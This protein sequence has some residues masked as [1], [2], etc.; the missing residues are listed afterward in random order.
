MLFA[1][2]S[3]SVSFGLSFPCPSAMYTSPFGANATIT[4]SHSSRCPFASSQ[5]PRRPLWPRRQQ[6]LAVGAD[7]RDGRVARGRNPD[8]VL[9]VDRH[10]VRL[11]LIADHIGADLQD[12]LVVRIE[13]EELRLPHVGALKHPEVAFRIERDRRDAAETWRQYILDTRTCTPSSASIGRAASTGGEFRRDARTTASERNLGLRR[14][15]GA[16]PR[17]AAPA[18]L[19]R[20]LLRPRA[21]RHRHLAARLDDGSAGGIGKRSLEKPRGRLADSRPFDGRLRLRECQRRSQHHAE[22]HHPSEA[23]SLHLCLHA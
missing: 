1:G 16:A 4:G 5:S 12:E 22:R 3:E 17:A 9:G 11:G 6:Q 13:L 7:L 20:R 10:A 18:P 19:P 21:G 23:T 8:V 2:S 15:S 14:L